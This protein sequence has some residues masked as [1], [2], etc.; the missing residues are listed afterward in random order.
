[1]NAT[2]GGCQNLNEQN[3]KQLCSFAKEQK[4]GGVKF[5]EKNKILQHLCFY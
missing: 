5:E 4:W 3:K 2:T 1:M